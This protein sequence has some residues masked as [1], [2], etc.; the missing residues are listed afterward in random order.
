MKIRQLIRQSFMIGL[1]TMLIIII[2]ACMV[3][4]NEPKL[5]FETNQ[6]GL[7]MPINTDAV[8]IN[9]QNIQI[10]DTVSKSIR[11][12]YQ[13]LNL[14]KDYDNVIEV[15]GNNLPLKPA[16]DTQNQYIDG[17]IMLVGPHVVG[18]ELKLTF[19]TGMNIYGSYD[20]FALRNIKIEYDGVE[21]WSDEY[22]ESNF[23]NTAIKFGYDLK[24]EYRFGYLS[25]RV[26][27]FTLPNTVVD[28]KGA[29]LQNDS[30]SFDLKFN[31]KQITLLNEAFID[32]SINLND[33]EIITDNKTLSVEKAIGTDIAV[34][35]DGYQIRTD[36]MFSKD[37]W[38]SGVHELL[39]VGTNAL[40]FKK[41]KNISFTLGDVDDSDSLLTYKA[42]DPGVG[43]KLEDKL[44]TSLGVEVNLSEYETNF[45]KYGILYL[46]VDINS[47][48]T[49]QWVGNT[50]LG[51]S[52]VM[53][54]YNKDSKVFETVSTT[55]Y[56]EGLDE[57]LG[58][59][60][61]AY[62]DDYIFNNKVIVRIASQNNQEISIN[63][64]LI[65][66]TDPQYIT[67]YAASVGQISQNGKDAF[68]SVY[69]YMNN[70]YEEEK[71]LYVVT[72]GDYV[73]TMTNQQ[74]E[75]EA[76]NTSFFNK[77]FEANIPF[78]TSSGN[79][80]VGGTSDNPNSNDGGNTLDDKL[81][82]TYYQE[83]LG[84]H[85]FESKPWFKESYM[86]GR[87]RYDQVT[88]NQQEFIFLYLGWGS[89]IP[90][91]HVSSLDINYAKT[92]LEQHY[93]KTVVLITHDYQ[94]NKGNRT[95]TGNYVYE[96]LVSKYKNIKMVLSGHVNG[97]S[98]RIDAIDDDNDG[99][100]DREVIQV[101]TDLQ[102]E[103]NLFGASFFR[104]IGLDY[105]NNKMHFQLYSP[106]Y[107]DYDLTVDSNPDYVLEFRTF[108]FDFNLSNVAYAMISKGMN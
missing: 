36:F 24:T 20:T 85:Q 10:Y 61:D 59:N 103:E 58:F 99:I 1:S 95:L 40:G 5:V 2:A 68:N 7:I 46:E 3:Q 27:T 64:E 106:Y 81:I 18:R 98:A 15:N 41:H 35:M 43:A 93:D 71:L 90:M 75:W 54:A 9:D 72:S 23:Y 66:F 25:E 94:G 16:S 86:N 30:Q 8:T 62:D 31:D 44:P 56:D 101:L 108:D 83:H 104:K 69:T 6:L 11:L 87:S 60:Y 70:A 57:V 102:E 67:R 65:H 100:F 89:S 96:Q 14:D 88:I 92:V 13:S 19:K 105:E 77:M 52:L 33:D 84:D 74:K 107:N 28:S 42:Y 79:H 97:T 26:V 76:I 17:E 32:F 50:I 80:D 78:G 37:A 38:S 29:L 34:Y 21:Y 47:D 4:D 49:I 63:Q 55:F 91:I 53:Q 51:R 48:K 73:Q 82:Y 12:K 39:V 45:S 22:S